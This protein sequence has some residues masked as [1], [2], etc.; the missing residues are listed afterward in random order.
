MTLKKL[1][2][3]SGSDIMCFGVVQNRMLRFPVAYS[4]TTPSGPATEEKTYQSKRK[5]GTMDLH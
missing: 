2:H 4:A 5:L 3:D 1:I